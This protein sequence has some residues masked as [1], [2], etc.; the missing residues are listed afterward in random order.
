VPSIVQNII[1]LARSTAAFASPIRPECCADICC[2]LHEVCA[3][4]ST[5]PK[6]WPKAGQRVARRQPDEADTTSRE[7]A[8]R[9]MQESDITPV[10]EE[11]HTSSLGE[12]KIVVPA[13][14]GAAVGAAAGAA[15][16]RPHKKGNAARPT[17]PTLFYMFLLLTPFVAANFPS[18]LPRA[19]DYGPIAGARQT[20]PSTKATTNK[21]WLFGKRWSCHKPNQNCG[22]SGCW[23]PASQFCCNQP[24]GHYGLCAASNGESC[25]GKMCCPENTECRNEGDFL[26][27]PKN[28]SL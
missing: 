23:D 24:D 10:D 18:S 11:S 1:L 21:R 26:C 28:S 8:L 5:G 25:C 17:T 19:N 4:S 22:S 16:N 20:D 12:S 7:I 9:Q 27:Y 2:D 6:C 3:R 15:R 13:A 14:A